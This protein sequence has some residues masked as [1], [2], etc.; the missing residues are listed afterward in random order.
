MKV[1]Y[2]KGEQTQILDPLTS[3]QKRTRK[4]SPRWFNPHTASRDAPKS[5]I[6]QDT[7]RTNKDP[8]SE[9]K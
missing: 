3:T 2:V 4:W 7:N 5:V 6:I 9:A 8:R 1:D